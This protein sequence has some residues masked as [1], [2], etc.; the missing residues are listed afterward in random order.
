MEECTHTLQKIHF[1]QYSDAEKR[2][3]S[4]VNVTEA[5]LYYRNNAKVGGLLDGRMGISDRQQAC[6][7]CKYSG[8]RCPGHFG[9]IEL[10]RP[11]IH[12]SFR[13]L[14]F[15]ILRS[16]CYF[17]S[18]LL[19]SPQDPFHKG[20]RAKQKTR[21][22]DVYNYC[23]KIKKCPYCEAPQPTFKGN[24]KH[25]ITFRPIF[26]DKEGIFQSEEEKQWATSALTLEK[27]KK[28]LKYIPDDHLAI[29][30]VN[31]K[32]TKIH[33][34]IM[35]VILVP[36]PSM[37]PSISASEGTVLKGQDDITGSLQDIV[38]TNNALR[39]LIK[40]GA[41]PDKIFKQQELLQLHIKTL[42]H[43]DSGDLLSKKKNYH[44]SAQLHKTRRTIYQRWKGKK[45]RARN[46]LCGKRVDNAARAV[47]GA[48]THHDIDELGVPLIVATSLTIPERVND[49]N[50]K[51]LTGAVLKGKGVYGGAARVE[52]A[53]GTIID[54]AV[55]TNR[56]EIH[57]KNSWVVRRHLLDGDLVLF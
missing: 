5:G 41:D 27:I 32:I 20:L 36:P 12:S 2:R 56:S 8:I 18:R 40:S 9:H 6:W 14:V 51:R 54:L 53:D 35:N 42:V 55:V 3:I 31:P 26:Q 37:R 23:C 4:V 22:R 30:G 47:V 7:T 29:L 10:A 46:N 33:N 49:L 16:V 15:K 43:N 13:T 17:C 50:K 52:L 57:L 45:G 21:L 19:I 39:T 44:S 25:A 1:G 34:V 48:D 28:I 24:D 11:V 38:K